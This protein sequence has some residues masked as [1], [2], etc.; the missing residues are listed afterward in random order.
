MKRLFPWSGLRALTLGT[1]LA[2]A[3]GLAGQAAHAQGTPAETLTG[4][5]KLPADAS[6][7]L[8]VMDAVFN[9]LSESR[10][11]V[12]DGAT[13]K[14]LGMVPTA[15]NGHM[16]VSPDGA[17]IYVMTTYHSR[18][19]R[20]ERTDVVEVWDAHGLT[21]EKEIILPARRVQGLNYRGMFRQSTDGN[22]IALQNATPAVSTTVVDLRSGQATQEITATAGCWSVIPKPNK[23][24]SFISIC[25]DGALLTL[26]LDEHGKLASQSRSKAMFP[27]GQD[28]IFI[29]PALE[30]TQVHFVSY[31]GNVYTADFSGDDMRFEA[32][33]SLLDD[34]DKA[35][36]WRPGGYNLID[37]H[38]PTRRLYV[39]MHPKG[40]EGTH[41]NPAAEIWVYD[42]ATKKRLARVPG[43]DALSLSVAQGKKPRL[44]TLDGGNAHVYDIS[45]NAPKLLRSIEGAAESALQIEPQP[46]AG[47]ING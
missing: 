13:G 23:P 43:Q 31:N 4:D 27:V 18:M 1:A 47:A 11:N 44:L 32:P 38:R 22:F 45:G 5:L 17:K 39:L 20:G 42:M 46:T 2:C 8:Y 21:F 25:G 9:H 37:I 7:R 36:G 14:F 6:E 24:R 12:F 26:D 3:L 34:K 30:K 28:P 40:A 33:W 41:K 35:E 10:V 16:M 19:T 15:Y 29:A